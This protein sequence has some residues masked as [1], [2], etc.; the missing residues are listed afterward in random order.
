MRISLRIVLTCS[1]LLLCNANSK[2]NAASKEFNAQFSSLVH[3]AIALTKNKHASQ[4][5]IPMIG[6]AGGSGVGKSH[7]SEELV[8]ALQEQGV[9]AK[10]LKLDDFMQEDPPL[11]ALP[12]HPNF[13]HTQAHDIL[14][15]ICAGQEKNIRKPV[16]ICR[17][18]RHIKSEEI[19]SLENVD[20]LVVE[21]EFALHGPETY[22]L[23]KYTALRIFIDASIENM[24]RWQ[25]ER[26]RNMDTAQSFEEYAKNALPSL[27]KYREHAELVKACAHYVLHKAEN[28]QYQLQKV[29]PNSNS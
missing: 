8:R 3:D 20:L 11:D 26:K 7:F 15:R 21:G 10:M 28:H 25:F 13:N 14:R 2:V 17:E 27:Q 6:V 24:C 23:R 22:D 5:A 29:N 19:M 1:F 9:K 16:W 18:G 4:C 12:L